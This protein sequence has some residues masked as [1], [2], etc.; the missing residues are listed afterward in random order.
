[1]NI[2]YCEYLRIGSISAQSVHVYQVV[3]NLVTLG[4][5]VVLLKAYRP[6]TE[7]EFRVNIQSSRKQIRDSIFG[8]RMIRP[9]RGLLYFLWSL[10]ID[11]RNFFLAFKAIVKQKERFDVIYRRSHLFN[12]EYFLAK[13]FRIPL[14]KEVNGIGIGEVKSNEWAGKFT[15]RIIDSI[16]RFSKPRADKI[17]AVTPQLKKVLC[18]DY[19]VPDDKIVVI[20]NGTDTE[21]FKPMD[22]REA[23]EKLKL[24]QNYSYVCFVGAFQA[25]AGI[26]NIIHSAPLVLQ[27]CPDTR[28]LLVGDGL[29]KQK[30]INLAEQN[31]ISDKIIFTGMVSHQVVPLYISASDVCVCP[32]AENARNSQVGGGSPLKL[33]EY[34]ACARPVVIGSVVDLSK[35]VLK[36]GSGLA[37]DMRNKDELA[38]MLISLLKDGELRKKMGENGRKAALEKYSW[39]KVAEQIVEVCQSVTRQRQVN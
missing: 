6:R 38:R 33:P 16:E 20:P 22:I 11:I 37:V 7:T 1:M 35:D 4:H 2:L 23:R 30:I 32:I 5:N 17:V 19:G 8:A 27:E 28:F 29:M 9:I 24:N 34:M 25:W 12:S 15:L 36:T 18:Q 14:V 39:R 3:K 21:L 31:G 13:L 26:E 10:I